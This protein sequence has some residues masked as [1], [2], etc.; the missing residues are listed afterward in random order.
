MIK[1]NV[2]TSVYILGLVIIGLAYQSVER[3]KIEL[4]F[5]Y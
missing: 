4:F 2:K 5:W 1:R 3:I